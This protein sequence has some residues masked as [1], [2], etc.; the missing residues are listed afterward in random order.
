MIKTLHITNSYHPASGGIRTFY[1]TLLNA[2][3]RHRRFVRLVVPAAETSVEEVGEFGR[4]YRLAAPPSPVLDSRYRW[5]LPHTYA[6]PHD[7][8]LRRIL[9]DE[10]PDL[11]EVCDK[12]W[13]IYLSGVLR[14]RWIPG[15]PVPVTV[16]L[17]CERLDDNVAAYLSAGRAARYVSRGYLRRCYAPRFDFH[18]AV[19]QYVAEEVRA[20]LPDRLKGRLVVAPM[21][22]DFDGFSRPQDSAEFRKQLLGRIGGGEKT[23]LLLYAGR[24]SQ[25]KNLSVLA[26]MMALLAQDEQSDYRLVIAGDGPVSKELHI[27]LDALAPARSLF[28]GQCQPADLVKLYHAADFFIHPNPREPF[29]IAPLEAM[30]AGLPLVAPASG[31]V[32]TYANPENAWLTENTPLSFAQAVQSVHS[33][34]EV[35]RQKTARARCTAQRHSWLRVTDS[36][37]Q[38]YDQLHASSVQK[39]PATDP[40]HEIL[41][42]RGAPGVGLRI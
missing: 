4:I 37:F 41:P 33:D 16:G 21:G 6:W 30:A 36:Y 9:A 8:P 23:R 34:P 24:L 35:C 27:A 39:V 1:N 3:N 38:L 40:A 19:S 13:L 18:I 5:L 15:V 12:F 14:H 22:V 42:E 32:I 7:S 25:E 31:G 26:P 2:A 10:R 11:I 20:V 29:G 17:S 28:L